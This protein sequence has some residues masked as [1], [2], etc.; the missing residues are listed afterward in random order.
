MY[1]VFSSSL[2][3]EGAPSHQRWPKGPDRILLHKE[4][5]EKVKAALDELPPDQRMA[6]VFREVEGSLTGKWQNRW[7]V[8]SER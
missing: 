6:I 2:D 8:L 1:R 3:E 5:E 4:L 7:A